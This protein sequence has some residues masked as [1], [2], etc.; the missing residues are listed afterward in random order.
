MPSLLVALDTDHRGVS[1]SDVIKVS[2]RPATAELAIIGT[3]EATHLPVKQTLRM[4]GIPRS[5]DHQ[6]YARWAAWNRILSEMREHCVEFAREPDDLTP[7]ALAVKFTNENRP[8]SPDNWRY[9]WRRSRPSDM[10]GCR[11]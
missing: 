1:I 8:R 2:Q 5:S 10:V 11:R 7:R 4:F 3:V 6:C 9:R